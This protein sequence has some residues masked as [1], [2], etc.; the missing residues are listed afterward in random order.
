MPIRKTM[1]LFVLVI[2]VGITA[3]VA[4]AGTE[5]VPRMTKQDLNAMLESPDLIILDVR[6]GR[7]WEDS[8]FKIKGAKRTDPSLFPFWKDQLPKDRILVLYCT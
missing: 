8:E 5:N 7:D 2:S 3:A 4:Y 1:I 6:A